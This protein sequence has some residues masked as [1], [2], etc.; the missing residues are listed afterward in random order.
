LEQ[1]TI[2]AS[3]CGTYIPDPELAHYHR[4][5]RSIRAADARDVQRGPADPRDHRDA[6]PLTG[7]S[8]NVAIM[9][10]SEL[11]NTPESVNSAR[12]RAIFRTVALLVAGVVDANKATLLE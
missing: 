3:D 11:K 2:H 4:D 6:E 5:V 9:S 12:D 7:H 1:C 10:I 8:G